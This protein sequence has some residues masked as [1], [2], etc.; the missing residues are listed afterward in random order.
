MKSNMGAIIGP[1]VV[2]LVGSI[3]VAT[4]ESV[5]ATLRAL[6]EKVERGDLVPDAAFEQAKKDQDRIDTIREGIQG[7][8]PKG[9]A[10]LSPLSIF[11]SLFRR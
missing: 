7:K 9:Q 10:P 5:A 6:A 8:T 4:R 3:A 2:E 11:R 1:I